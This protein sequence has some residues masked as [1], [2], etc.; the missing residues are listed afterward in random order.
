MEID[1]HRGL[2]KKKEKGGKSTELKEKKKENPQKGNTN[3]SINIVFELI[4]YTYIYICFEQFENLCNL[5][6]VYAFW[7]SINC[8]PISRL[9]TKDTQ[10]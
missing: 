7:E 1:I 3:P 6:I 5:M 10:S 8:V 2:L 4:V 9:C